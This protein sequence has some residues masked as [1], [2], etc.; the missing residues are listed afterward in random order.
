MF[1]TPKKSFNNGVVPA[2]ANIIHTGSDTEAAELPSVPLAGVLRSTITVEHQ[3]PWRSAQVV[4]HDQRSQYQTGRHGL[5]NRPTH[6]AARIQI[7]DNGQIHTA[8]TGAAVS[9]ITRPDMVRTHWVEVL[10]QQVIRYAVD[11]FAL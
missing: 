7:H 9:R 3:A 6:D 1:Q 5:I 8:F 11:V 10:I 2:G 4:S